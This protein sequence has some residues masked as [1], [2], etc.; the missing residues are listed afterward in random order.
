MTASGECAPASLSSKCLPGL[1]Q[2]N[3]PVRHGA[4]AWIAAAPLLRRRWL[5]TRQLPQA[6]VAAAAATTAATTSA[7]AQA[8]PPPPPTQPHFTVIY[9]GAGM[10]I[11]QLLARVKILHVAVVSGLVLPMA[12]VWAIDAQTQE[13][14]SE[15]LENAA[16]S[17]DPQLAAKVPPPPPPPRVTTATLAIAVASAAATGGVLVGLSLALRRYVGELALNLSTNEMRVAT[18]SFWGRR[19]NQVYPAGAVIPQPFASSLGALTTKALHPMQLFSETRPFLLSVRY[20]RVVHPGL[21]LQLLRGELPAASE[22]PEAAATT[23]PS[24]TPSDQP[25]PA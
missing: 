6:S 14:S 25:P 20:G 18:L 10:Q 8:Q 4:H 3:S 19:V 16:T 7:M 24:A 17:S 21:F 15:T 2:R 13:A 22:A 11:W 23:F 9:K 5:S 12:A 1:A